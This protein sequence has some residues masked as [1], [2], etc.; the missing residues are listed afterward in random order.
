MEDP[1]L[2]DVRVGRHW[3]Q[4]A[5]ASLGGWS[6]D[7]IP[8]RL[9]DVIDVTLGARNV[10]REIADD[11]VITWF[12]RWLKALERL[13]SCPSEK[14]IISYPEEPWEWA[15]CA[16]PHLSLS[17]YRLGLSGEVVIRNA[18]VEARALWDATRRATEQL[19][20]DLERTLGDS[21]QRL[22]ESLTRRLDGLDA[23]LLLDPTPDLLPPSPREQIEVHQRALT[24]TL[25]FDSDDRDLLFYAGAP[26]FDQ[27]ALLFAGALDVQ[28]HGQ[29]LRIGA[30][31]HLL[32]D[33]QRFTALLRRYLEHKL[34]GVPWSTRCEPGP[35]EL[36]EAPSPEAL[37]LRSGEE[38]LVVEE[39][40][41]VDALVDALTRLRAWI[42][43]RNPAQVHN[44]RFIDFFSEATGLRSW[45]QSVQHGPSADACARARLETLRDVKGQRQGDR[46]T[47]DEGFPYP[48]PV[49]GLKRLRCE[50]VW[51]LTRDVIDFEG[52]QR[53]A[54]TGGILSSSDEGLELLSRD[55][56]RVQWRLD[57]PLTKLHQ[58]AGGLLIT[59]GADSIAMLDAASGQRRWSRGGIDEPAIALAN[60]ASLSR[61][62]QRRLLVAVTA[63]AVE[64]LNVE[65]GQAHW[66]HALAHG[67][68]IGIDVV[69][70]SLALCSDDGFLEVINAW[71]GE[72]LWRAT[73]HGYPYLPPRFH[74]DLLLVFTEDSSNETTTLLTFDRFNG[75]PHGVYKTEGLLSHPPL[76]EAGCAWLSLDAESGW[77]WE[78]L[79]LTTTERLWSRRAS[80]SWER[81]AAPLIDASLRC[82]IVRGDT[83]HVYA[84]HLDTGA[85]SWMV[86][87][88]GE[89]RE[90]SQSQTLYSVCGVLLAHH[91]DAC[92]IAPSSG[93][94]LCHIDGLAK[95]PAVVL[96]LPDLSLVIGEKSPLGDRLSLY[97]VGHFLAI[98]Q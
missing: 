33:A 17:L 62:E 16:R 41:L 66:R 4:D 28:S 64:A 19:I 52:L 43:E 86:D 90:A 63:N 24:V 6:A 87:L 45:Y 14:V 61:G 84:I 30:G 75:H 49:S 12:Q 23:P 15:L 83:G 54:V 94:I 81:F 65:D 97:R 69:G 37:T 5:Q 25:C 82:L 13:A 40:T 89:A 85:L 29:R 50:P 56:G 96:P 72:S 71:S 38:T 3:I 74:R 93:E 95:D 9:R 57:I 58:T 77:R 27:H 48:I 91:N 7:E 1:S 20:R 10:T 79:D 18:P 2:I 21:A 8:A 35:L 44:Q 70:A 68:L 55:E 92:L 76:I 88:N 98:I 22:T 51:S 46:P 11:Q 36:S 32:I 47:S 78:A 59:D 60:V 73:L 34:L 67:E 80:R 42:L 31:A 26:A 39:A 53:C